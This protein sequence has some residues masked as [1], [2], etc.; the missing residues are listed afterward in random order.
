MLDWL[1]NFVALFDVCYFWRIYVSTALGFLLAQFTVS[2]LP[3][4]DLSVPLLV[5]SLVLPA[6]AGGLWHRAARAHD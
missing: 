2:R 3:A 5:G 4:E 1:D 6:I